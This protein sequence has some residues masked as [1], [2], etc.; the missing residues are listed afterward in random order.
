MYNEVKVETLVSISSDHKP[1][2]ASCGHLDVGLKKGVRLFR[3]EAYWD[4]ENTCSFE[5]DQLG[6]VMIIA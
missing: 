3:Y 6:E 5:V 4:L 1:L 2:L